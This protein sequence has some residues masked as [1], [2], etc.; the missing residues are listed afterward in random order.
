MQFWKKPPYLRERKPRYLRVDRSSGL[1]TPLGCMTLMQ[2]SSP[3][4]ERG[5]YR[6]ESLLGRI[7]QQ[8][9]WNLISLI[10]TRT[11]TNESTHVLKEVQPPRRDP[12]PNRPCLLGSTKLP[13]EKLRSRSPFLTRS[14]TNKKK[15][16]SYP[17]K[18]KSAR[19]TLTQ[20]YH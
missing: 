16:I 4:G 12:S 8:S 7:M 11:R 1:E 2:A 9:Q 10:Y 20:Y 19:S 3:Q 17:D 14:L 6:L 13:Q 5:A 18:R 15:E